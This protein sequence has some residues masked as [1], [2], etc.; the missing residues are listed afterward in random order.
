MDFVVKFARI[1]IMHRLMKGRHILLLAVLLSCVSCFTEKEN[2]TTP[3]AAITT[4][5]IGYYNVGFHDVNDSGRDTVVYNREGGVMYPMTIDQVGNRI[6]NVDS[7]AYGSNLKAV[8]CNVY[9]NGVVFYTYADDLD[10]SYLWSMADSLDFTRKLIFGIQSTDGSYTRR[11][12]VDVN[13][14][15]VFPDSLLWS[16]KDSVGFATLSSLSA[17]VRDDS[18]FCFGLDGTGT[19]SVTSRDITRG[20]WNGSTPLTGISA[21]WQPRVTLAGGIF[22]T[23][24]GGSLYSS[25][26]A[27]NWTV[28]KSGIKSVIS[29]GEDYGELQV[30]TTDGKILKSTDMT[31]WSEM[32]AV[33]AGFPDSAAVMYRYPLATNANILRSVLAGIDGDSGYATLWTMLSTDSVWT[34]VDLPS[35]TGLRLP[36]SEQMSLLRYD[37]ALFAMGPGIKGFVQS[38]DNGI[39]WYYCDRYAYDYSSWNRYMQLPVELDVKVSD[40]VAVTDNRGGIWIMT[41]DGQVWHGAITRLIK[42]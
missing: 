38:N 28:A 18:L 25:S 10:H 6:F 27:V 41:A 30:V 35:D 33:P 12:K 17:I 19:P 31:S 36:A 37:D 34:A 32:Q 24:S 7:M 23:V 4:F 14:R 1:K 42:R 39:T 22:Y 16:N 13:V 15:T 40:P 3:Q 20:S 5:I 11:Y 9:G 29:A 8:T 2:S 21:G 26:D